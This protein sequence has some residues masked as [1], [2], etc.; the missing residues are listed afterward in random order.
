MLIIFG[1]LPGSGKTTIARHLAQEISGVYVRVDTIEQSIREYHG[2]DFEVGPAG[3]VAAYRVAEDNLALGH[4]VI[5]DSVNGLRVTRV[6]WLL[7][8]RRACV[9]AVEIEVVCSDQTEHRRRVETRVTDVAGLIKP[10]WKAIIE[11][12]YEDWGQT[13]IAVDTA[14]MNAN[15]IVADLISKLKLA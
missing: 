1:G 15:E 3:Y 5:A 6:A 13:P 10:S 8:A 9:S 4:T 2:V 12:H 11:R 7:V 14:T